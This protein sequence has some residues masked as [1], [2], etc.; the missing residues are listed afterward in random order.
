MEAGDDIET[1]LS[2][3]WA[4]REITIEPRGHAMS[5][6]GMSDHLA[7][8]SRTPL[9]AR[10]LAFRD[11]RGGLV[12][13]CCL[14]MAMVTHAMWNAAV[15]RMA[16]ALGETFDHE[17]FVLTCTHTHSSPGGCGHEAMYNWVTPGFVSEHLEAVTDASVSASVAAVA[18]AAPAVVALGS[19]AF[20]SDEEV[21]WNRAIRAHQRNPEATERGPA[22]AHLAIDRNMSVLTVSRDGRPQAVL[23]LFGVH[24]TCLGNHLGALDGDNKGR[25]ARRTE[26]VLAAAGAVDPVAIFAQATAGDVSPHYH[27]PG[28]S[29]RRRAVRRRGDVQYAER[30]GVLQS[31]RAMLAVHAS[32]DELRGSVDGVL[33]F[34]DFR[35]IAVG[36][37]HADG[38]TDARTVDPCHGVAFFVGTPVDGKGIP[39]VIGSAAQLLARRIRAARLRNQG[40]DPRGDSYHR[41]LYR[42][43][44]AKDILLEATPKL[45]LGSPLQRAPLPAVADPTVAEMKRQARAGAL[46]RSPLV[47][48]VLPVQIVRIGPLAIVCCPGEFTTVAGKRLREVAR[49]TLSAAGI[50]HVRLLT[51][52]NDYM[53]YVTTP[54]EYDE[55][56]YEGGHTIFGRWTLGAF[57]TRTAKLATQLSLPRAD[58]DHDRRRRPPEVPAQELA[59]RSDLGPHI[60]RPPYGPRTWRTILRSIDRETA[61]EISSLSQDTNWHR[62]HGRRVSLRVEIDVA[63]DVHRLFTAMTDPRSAA[64]LYWPVRVTHV[65]DGESPADRF[66]AGSLRS[67]SPIRGISYTEKILEKVQDELLTWTSVAGAP[68][69]GHL[70]SM[71]FVALDSGRSRLVEHVEL[72]VGVPGVAHVLAPIV[73]QVKARAF[74][75]IRALL[76]R[77]FDVEHQVADLLRVSTQS[78]RV[79]SSDLQST[80]DPKWT[81]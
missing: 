30:N 68:I 64:K 7:Y 21:A 11:H 50:R 18:S 66:G 22:D 15:V 38:Y 45:V 27:G 57:R 74:L 19:E 40:S 79:D 16:A 2:V 32:G 10:A 24:A 44:G 42:H 1:E 60:E 56:T 63:V 3:G 13:I 80:T 36:E 78:T 72:T 17:G 69:S 9:Y 6:Y 46:D 51:Y 23:S 61:S 81:R 20:P 41:E 33:E 71:R 8:T 54:E 47:P 77:R 26:Q 5:G 12:V 34:G 35:D 4:R 14:D 31:D 70:G 52:A 48:T 59:A 49:E 37:E 29:R 39:R 43:Q 75:R 65:R 76:E 28:Q 67:F 55:Q 53:G 25:A 58:R 62:C 73:W